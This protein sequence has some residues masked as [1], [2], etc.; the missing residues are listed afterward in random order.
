M[1]TV[2]VIQPKV[3]DDAQRLLRVAAYCRVSS[4]S[5]DQLNSYNSQLTYYSHKFEKSETEC[6]IDIYADEGISGTSEENRTEFLRLI[7]DCRK[8][9]IDRVYTKSISRFARN[10]RDCLKNIRELTSLGITV[11]VQYPNQSI[12]I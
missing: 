11:I 4:S 7:D 5:D 2:T 8:G 10:T 3:A 9:R 12:Q 1:P 6:L